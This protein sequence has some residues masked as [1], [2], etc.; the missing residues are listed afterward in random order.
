MILKALEIDDNGGDCVFLHKQAERGFARSMW[1]GMY[2][3]ILVH[4]KF[5]GGL[6][7]KRGERS[8]GY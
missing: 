2:K 6:N 8:A 3:F 4:N 5:C 1:Y 7:Q